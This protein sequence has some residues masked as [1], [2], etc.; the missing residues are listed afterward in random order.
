MRRGL[1][2]W[3][4]V[5]SS[6]GLGAVGPASGGVVLDETCVY[7]R[8]YRFA[9]SRYSP[10]ALKAE[11]QRVLG[12]RGL[13]RVR[14][15][16][17]RWL[18]QHGTDPGTVDW[19]DH[20]VCAMLGA[21]AFNPATTAPPPA[22]W[23]QA[24]FDDGSWVRRRGPF[25]ATP[26]ARITSPIL[27][28]YDG[29]VDLRL[30]AAHYRAR[31]VVD[32]PGAAGAVTLRAVYSGGLRAFVNGREVARGHL[33]AGEL[34]D[35]TPGAD[36]PAEAYADTGERL[37]DRTLGPVRIAPGLLHKGVNVLAIE[38]RA[39]DF[40]PVVLTRPRQPN[41]GGP[42]RP[43]PHAR[44]SRLTL[45]SSAGGIRDAT[46]RPAGVQVW[47]E[48]MH[49]RTRSTDC[50]Q[51][52]EGA[53]TI[54]LVG[55]RNGTYSAQVLFGSDRP[56]KSMR[57]TV[58]D[59]ARAGGEA[60]LDASNIRVFSAVPYPA[61]QWTLRRLG[62]ERGLGASFPTMAEL[63]RHGAMPDRNQVY[64]FDQLRREPAG[65]APADTCRPIWLSVR[66]PADAKP[67]RYAGT[68]RVEDASIPVELEVVDWTLPDPKDFRTVVACEQ[69]PY[70]VAKQ[71]GVTCW[72]DRHVELL[73]GS[74]RHLGR[75][76]NRWLNVPVLAGTE[77][78]NGNDS[79]IRWIRRRDGAFAFDYTV[80]DRYLDL[81]LKHLGRLGTIQFTVMHGMRSAATA[82]EPP[83][84]TVY[85]E[86]RRRSF[87]MDVTSAKAR[88]AWLA[89]ARSLHAHLAD[90]GLARAMC[91][92]YPLEQEADPGLKN[93]LAAAVP[94]V[95]WIAGPHEMMANGTYAKNER[96]YKIVADIR[97]HGRWPAFRDDQG[98]KSKT[99]HLLNP[100]VGGTAIALHTTSLPFAYRLLADRAIA[101]GRSGFTRVGAD[102]W[103]GVHY[104]GMAIP[105]YLTGIGV[106]FVLWPGPDGA[107]TSARFEALREGI[108]EAEARIFIEQ[109]L[110][111]RP[112][113]DPLARRAR[114]AL[115]ENSRETT[116]L[117]GNSIVRDM[118]AY[119]YRW[120]E[121]S[122]RVY[123]LAAEVARAAGPRPR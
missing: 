48:D 87:R 86:S 90:K 10:K 85:D 94:S 4:A 119:S 13:A 74:F 45:T 62:D 55:A 102:E 36:Y 5:G 25:Q 34:P 61:S 98:W 65:P 76:G 52:G 49:H 22:D 69:N 60:R 35:D 88:G 15:D 123:R 110:D 6:W 53:G 122:R 9:V 80:L 50:L 101:M 64:L 43:F 41:W 8:Y 115:A 37:R 118:E 16:T 108:Q 42:M 93:V 20:C 30:R 117:L 39:S 91:W 38:V 47:T 68:V 44:L 92:G 84:V 77:F 17:D 57:V 18:R 79:P 120:Q 33:P 51:P 114:K 1:A 89:L 78:G 113:G 105:K 121:R 100:R 46:R 3:V 96:F 82:P 24:N 72:S 81:A 66:I 103:A 73:A 109:A 63:A 70:A 83:R 56:L 106:L 97:Y 95:F 14:R 104:S 99:M 58:G 75:I 32:D 107:E 54:R 19:R 11:G 29:S 27:G 21:R 31:F 112:A 67:G 40:H 116:F 71:Y 111:R 23:A 12:R 2:L 26:G 7:R 59:L 28:Q